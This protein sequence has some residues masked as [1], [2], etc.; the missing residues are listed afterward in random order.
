[1]NDLQARRL[2]DAYVA[3]GRNRSYRGVARKAQLSLGQVAQLAKRGRWQQ[4][5]IEIERR[6]RTTL[7]QQ[8]VQSL[9]EQQ[10]APLRARHA[11]F[12]KKLELA[13]R[14]RITSY[15]D[16]L[17]LLERGIDLERCVL[18]GR[19][20]V[21][22]QLIELLLLRMGQRGELDRETLLWALGHRGFAA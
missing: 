18:L 15:G 19:Y 16:A 8:I 21:A 14:C 5:L 3:M 2:F 4:R 7:D 13:S 22:E 1:M 10:L 9:V 11:L 6:E 17:E 12:T 20:D